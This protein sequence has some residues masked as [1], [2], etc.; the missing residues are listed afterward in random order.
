M[1]G[2]D[3]KEWIFTNDFHEPIHLVPVCEE[4]SLTPPISKDSELLRYRV[5]VYELQN[6][7]A[8]RSAYKYVRTEWRG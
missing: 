6:P 7:G 4:I 2:D 1:I 3:W 8:E 5:Y